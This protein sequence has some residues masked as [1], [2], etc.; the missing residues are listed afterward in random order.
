L[1][2]PFPLFVPAPLS[3]WADCTVAGLLGHKRLGVTIH[4]DKALIAA[5]ESVAGET[6]RLMQGERGW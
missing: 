6:I 3:K 2:L 5:A 1:W 4:L